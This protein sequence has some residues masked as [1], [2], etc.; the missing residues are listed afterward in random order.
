MKYASKRIN[1]ALALATLTV[2][3]ITPCQEPSLFARAIA[4]AKSNHLDTVAAFAAPAAIIYTQWRTKKISEIRKEAQ[5]TIDR[6]QNERGFYTAEQLNHAYW[7]LDASDS[8]IEY[9]VSRNK[10]WGSL[11]A[12]LTVGLMY[13]LL[14]YIPRENWH[15]VFRITPRDVIDVVSGLLKALSNS[16][17]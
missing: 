15:V 8:D 5:T 6:Y 2:G 17:R 16:S 4:T 7:V 1:L 14:R 11:G 12:S 9:Y 10:L 13:S 3:Q